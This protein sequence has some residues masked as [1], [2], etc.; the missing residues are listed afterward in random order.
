MSNLNQILLYLDHINN[1]TYK[2]SENPEWSYVPTNLLENLLS[3]VGL[4]PTTSRDLWALW[5]DDV[6][7]P[8]NEINDALTPPF[9]RSGD[10][11][12]V[13][14]TSYNEANHPDQWISLPKHVVLNSQ[15][16]ESNPKRPIDYSQVC[17]WPGTLM[18]NKDGTEYSPQDFENFMIQTFGVRIKFLEVIFTNP[19]SG[20]P[21]GS[22]GRSDVFF[23]VHNEDIAGFAFPRLQYGIRWIE[24][25]YGNDQGYLYPERV[26]D[27]CTWNAKS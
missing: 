22:G 18:T 7:C 9:A 5:P 11:Q 3:Y 15:Q 14:V 8:L 2:H 17:V 6:M 19:D 24:D 26:R 16:V 4:N 12:T 25:V 27:Y 1:T 20:D 13:L 10:Y 21:I 23:A